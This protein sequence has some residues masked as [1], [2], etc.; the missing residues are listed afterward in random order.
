MIMLRSWTA[1]WSYVS[2]KI[3]PSSTR[4]CSI[5]LEA[6]SQTTMGD[7]LCFVISAAVL[8][9]D[10]SVLESN[11]VSHHRATNVASVTSYR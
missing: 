5:I 11:A 9:W 4:H 6:P 3:T 10:V 8:T 1:G 7:I 2:P